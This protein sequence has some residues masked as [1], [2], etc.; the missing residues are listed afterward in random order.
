MNPNSCF[1]RIG[2]TVA[3]GLCYLWPV[4][5]VP[6][7][8]AIDPVRPQ[9]PVLWRPYRAPEVPPARLANSE[10]M[11]SLIKG[12]TLYL[13][14]EDAVN[15]AIENNIDVEIARYNPISSAWSLERS[16]AG[17][18]LPG[19]PS[20]ASQVSSA[21]GGQGVLGS[22]AAAGVST[23]PSTGRSSAGNATISQIGP[24]AQTY[25]PAIQE[26]T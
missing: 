9:A 12:G 6:A 24:V 11:K 26:S 2:K 1:Y 8:S 3:L 14:A 13:T 19:V 17:G 10:R 16:L 18:A 5:L 21:A 7:Q 20:A 23:A 15:L 25:D 22:Q 4:S